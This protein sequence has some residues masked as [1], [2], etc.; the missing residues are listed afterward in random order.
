M[1]IQIWETRYYQV[2]SVRVR[3]IIF[4]FTVDILC[5]SVMTAHRDMELARRNRG[6]SGRSMLSS[7]DSIF[8][9]EAYQ[10]LTKKRR[11]RDRLDNSS[12]A[13][14]IDAVMQDTVER[15]NLLDIMHC[16]TTELQMQY[17]I[18]KIN[19]LCNRLVCAN[20]TC[21][22]IIMCF[23]IIIIRMHY[24][25]HFLLFFFYRFRI[26]SQSIT[27]TTTGSDSSWTRN[28]LKKTQ[29]G[30]LMLSD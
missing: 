27:Q 16:M 9:V 14:P 6:G 4:L 2:S 15:R 17:S 12:S 28:G 19:V 18:R 22:I 21:C 13:D 26:S 5:S 3:I 8:I 10:Q 7:D 1:L 20:T 30:C 29:I 23:A 25:H 11:K 24:Y